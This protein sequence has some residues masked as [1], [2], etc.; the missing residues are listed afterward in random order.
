MNLE[1]HYQLLLNQIVANFNSLEL[2]RIMSC[3]TDDIL[4]HYNDLTI[5]GSSDLNEFLGA[6]YADLS[7]YRL[8]KKLRTATEHTIGVEATASYTEKIYRRTHS[9]A[10]S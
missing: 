4:V 3:F 7:D 1:Q 9:G 5:H 2:H 10:D 8:E 6:R